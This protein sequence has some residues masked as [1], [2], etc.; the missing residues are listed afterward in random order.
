MTT[1]T[2]TRT[3]IFELNRLFGFY[4]VSYILDG[5]VVEKKGNFFTYD[6]AEQ[7]CDIWVKQGKR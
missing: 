2:S 5:E 4:E 1:A 3:A 6:A 7:A